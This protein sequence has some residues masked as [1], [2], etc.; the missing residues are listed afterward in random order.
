MTF[1][2]RNPNAVCDW[3]EY[4]RR[5][6][7]AGRRKG[8][9]HNAHLLKTDSRPV[10]WPLPEEKR[11]KFVGHK[12]GRRCRKY[13]VRGATRCE[14]H[15][16]L[17]EVPEHPANGRA[18]KRGE[19]GDEIARRAAG[20]FVKGHPMEHEVRMTLRALGIRGTAVNMKAAIEAQE[21]DENG[22]AWRKWIAMMGRETRRA[23]RVEEDDNDQSG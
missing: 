3:D 16:G 5:A 4:V 7:M 21:A 17:R 11:C 23:Q 8:G 12:L 15:G 10:L 6:R 13:A 22:R 9:S 19:I 2:Y 1:G 14:K 20:E 18:W